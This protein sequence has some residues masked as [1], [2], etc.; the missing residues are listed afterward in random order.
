MKTKIFLITA[1]SAFFSAQL[2]AS[3]GNASSL[4]ELL[5]YAMENNIAILQAKEA[6]EEQEGVIIEI[7]SNVLPNANLTGRY[8]KTDEELI[9][10]EIIPDSGATEDWGV[11]LEVS[12]LVYSGGGIRAA[13]KAQ[14]YAR[15]SALQ[16]MR[17]TIEQA[18]F[19]V[20]SS[21]YDALLAK[22]QIEVQKQNVKFLEEQ[23][24]IVKDR[25]EVE[26]VSKFDLLQSEVELANAQPALIRARNNY[27]TAIDVL[28]QVIGYQSSSEYAYDGSEIHGELFFEAIHYSLD[29]ALSSAMEQRPELLQLDALIKAREAGVDVAKSGSLPTISV[30]GAWDF[31]Q[32]PI[33]DRFTDALDGWRV[34]IRSSWALFDGRRTKG[35]IIQARS[36]L[37]QTELTRRDLELQI[38]VQVRRAISGLQEADEL[39]AAA[40]KVVEQAEE[41]LRL[42]EVR[43]EAGT[44]TQLELLQSQVSVTDART[45]LL[46]ANYSYLVAAAAFQQAIGNSSADANL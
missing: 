37:R 31:E 45:N 26:T 32:S 16:N 41:A 5:N 35:Q 46:S 12:Q 4:E 19:A 10:G 24:Q 25:Y 3:P 39:A 13:I 28:F 14:K 44:A 42:A 27:R 23:Y 30:F 11:S 36:Q 34:G 40:E 33:S 9:A 29:R 6:I 15:E 17:A 2:S 7:T 43:Y 8:S 22:E 20:R 1:L 21:F 18:V 38:E